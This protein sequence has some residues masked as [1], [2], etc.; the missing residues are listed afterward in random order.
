MQFVSDD[1]STLGMN[2]KEFRLSEYS[3]TNDF[4]LNGVHRLNFAP[5]GAYDSSENT[6]RFSATGSKNDFVIRGG[7]W[8]SSYNGGLFG[9]IKSDHVRA[10]LRCTYN[11]PDL[12]LMNRLPFDSFNTWRYGQG[13]GIFKYPWDYDETRGKSTPDGVFFVSDNEYLVPNVS[14][15]IFKGVPT[16]DA[17]VLN[18]VVEYPSKDGRNLKLKFTKISDKEMPHVKAVAHCKKQGLRLPTVREL[19]DFCAAGVTEPKYGPNGSIGR[20][21]A[22]ERC[23]KEVT[24]SL[25]ISSELSHAWYFSAPWGNVR[26]ADRLVELGVRCVEDS[27]A[28]NA[29]NVWRDGPESPIMDYPKRYNDLDPGNLAWI[30]QDELFFIAVDSFFS[31]GEFGPMYESFVAE[32]TKG[33]KGPSD[34]W[35]LMI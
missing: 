12:A 32:P 9:A 21:S 23:G 35:C 29:F 10:G 11:P 8:E 33:A 28:F 30:G 1:Y 7:H 6:G 26:P 20:Y 25:S 34:N 27:E 13:T 3:N 5:T 16:Q 19:F 4:P 18:D 17:K 24:W 22:T 31:S 2:P 15:S 14:H